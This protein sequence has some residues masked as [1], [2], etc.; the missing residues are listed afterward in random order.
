[1]LAH[2]PHAWAVHV[3]VGHTFTDGFEVLNLGGKSKA[4]ID[5]VKVLPADSGLKV[6]GV[7]LANPTRKD[8]VQVTW[9]WPPRDPHLEQSTIG[10]GL[11]A[12]ITPYSHDKN[13]WELLVGIKVTRPGYLVRRELEVDYHIGDQHYSYVDPATVAVC[14]LRSTADCPMPKLDQSS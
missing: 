3:S 5:S 11:G 7:R 12:T 2:D 9:N 1:M 4:V 14:T 13:T 8:G 6:V 10:P